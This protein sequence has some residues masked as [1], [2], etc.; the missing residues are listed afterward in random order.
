MDN[1][2]NLG[3][4]VSET[5]YYLSKDT[6]FYHHIKQYKR[7][8]YVFLWSE[9]YFSDILKKIKCSKALMS[10]LL[11]YDKKASFLVNIYESRILFH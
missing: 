4:I 8:N 3:K 7:E 2:F 10:D 1:F 5:L 6:L 11:L 9:F